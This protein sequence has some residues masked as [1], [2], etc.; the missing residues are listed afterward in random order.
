MAAKADQASLRASRRGAAAAGARGG[1]VR[2]RTSAIVAASVL[3]LGFAGIAWWWRSEA[4][5]VPPVWAGGAPAEATREAWSSQTLTD[6]SVLDQ[7]GVVRLVASVIDT[8]SSR[9]HESSGVTIDQ[10]QALALVLGSL[11]DLR[12]RPD[13]DAFVRFASSQASR[14]QARWISPGDRR[15]WEM[16]TVRASLDDGPTPDPADPAAALA[17]LVRVNL[18]RCDP[19]FMA[20]A[21]PGRAARV[22]FFRFTSRK[23]FFRR[24]FDVLGPELDAFWNVGPG[25][26]TLVTRK[27]VRNLEAVIP[28]GGVALGAVCWFV[29]QTAADRGPI[30]WRALFFYDPQISA[31]QLEA[32]GTQGSNSVA[33]DVY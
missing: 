6:M 25:T 30:A 13:P 33:V 31:W 23:D 9:S 7:A 26:P 21:G 5:R 29:V 4:R 19:R 18:E 28:P 16:V 2:C 14:G 17:R 27:P 24:S 8:D 22:V 20:V 3:L 15:E 12:A 11:L 1:W 32:A 10:R